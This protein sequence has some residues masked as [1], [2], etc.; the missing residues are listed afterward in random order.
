MPPS[1]LADLACPTVDKRAGVMNRGLLRTTGF[2]ALWGVCRQIV[3]VAG[4]NRGVGGEAGCVC[5]TTAELGGLFDEEFGGHSKRCASRRSVR[6]SGRVLRSDSN[7]AGG[8]EQS[9]ARSL[10][11]GRQ[12]GVLFET[13]FTFSGD[14]RG[15]GLRERCV[16]PPRSTIKAQ[17]ESSIR[18]RATGGDSG[19]KRK[20]RFGTRERGVGGCAAIRGLPTPAR[21]KPLAELAV[22][23]E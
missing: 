14:K 15:Q 13:G 5:E 6:L 22:P 7:G 1:K 17:S 23:Q 8:R 3:N 12:P 21:G 9:Q 16:L 2:D 11:S 18:M 19:V 20:F 10:S 4:G